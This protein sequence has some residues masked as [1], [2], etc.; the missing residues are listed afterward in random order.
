MT[1]ITA[2]GLP[3]AT[4]LETMKPTL[5]GSI[6]VPVVSFN[7]STEPVSRS[8]D[9]FMRHSS[10]RQSTQSSSVFARGY[11]HELSPHEALQ[12]IFDLNTSVFEQADSHTREIGQGWSLASCDFAKTKKQGEPESVHFQQQAHYVSDTFS[13]HRDGRFVRAHL[14]PQGPLG[15]LEVGS[16][17]QSL[18]MV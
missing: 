14:N 12:Y 16:R 4:V 13:R 11:F 7:S 1:K 18:E 10:Q 2:Y 6:R 5:F 15:V 17:G 3:A 9:A 8:L